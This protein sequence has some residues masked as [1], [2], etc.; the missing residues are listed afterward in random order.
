MFL[1]AL[2]YFIRENIHQFKRGFQNAI[3]VVVDIWLLALTYPFGQTTEIL[4][5]WQAYVQYEQSTSSVNKAPQYHIVYDLLFAPKYTGMVIWI[6]FLLAIS[7]LITGLWYI[8]KGWR[9]SRQQATSI[10]TK[11]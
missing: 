7:M 2:I 9:K 3:F 4:H 11:S 8:I 6:L 10:N 1:T 5:R